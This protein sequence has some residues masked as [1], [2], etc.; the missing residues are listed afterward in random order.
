M[1]EGYPEIKD[2]KW[3][4]L[5]HPDRSPNFAPSDFLLFLYLKNIWRAKSFRKTKRWKTKL[6]RGCVRRQRFFYEI[7]KLVPRLKCLDKGRDYV[8]K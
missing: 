8:E 6:P 4:V 1:Y 7:Q 3:D 2:T 5:Y